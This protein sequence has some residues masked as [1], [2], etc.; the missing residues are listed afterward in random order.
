MSIVVTPE[1]LTGTS[2][3]F[4][5]YLDQSIQDMGFYS[6][7]DGDMVQEK[8]LCNFTY[9]VS[10]LSLSVFHST[11]P[12]KSA[13]LREAS[14]LIAWGDGTTETILVEQPKTHQ[15]ARPGN[16]TVVLSVE[17]P[18]TDNIKKQIKVGAGASV[19]N[20][21]GTLT[22]QVPYSQAVVAQDYLLDAAALEPPQDWVVS[23]FTLSQLSALVPYGGGLREGVD[24]GGNGVLSMT[25]GYTA[26]TINGLIYMDYPGGLT[27]YEVAP[28]DYTPE[29]VPQL[30]IKQEAL[31]GITADVQ[32]YSEVQVERGKV[33]VF[34]HNLRLSELSSVGEATLYGNGFFTVK[35]SV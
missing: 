10:G 16:Y 25:D 35:K 30:L 29:V 8:D 22:L 31:L 26:Y 7:T 2:L 21:L 23:G 12:L 13:A 6:T 5:V 20:P 28:Q 3:Q 32:V 27:Y 15:Y 1:N 9:Q 14:F 24:A 18:W 33:S 11:N 4:L 17:S 34:E 19:D